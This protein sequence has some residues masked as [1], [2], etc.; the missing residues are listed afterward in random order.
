VDLAA[1]C[2]SAARQSA[3]RGGGSSISIAGALTRA[4]GRAKYDALTS[5]GRSSCS[6]ACANGAALFVFSGSPE[7][8]SWPCSPHPH[9]A[10]HAARPCALRSL[11][12][13]PCPGRVPH[14]QFPAALVPQPPQHDSSSDRTS[15]VA[16]T[17][18]HDEVLDGTASTLAG[19]PAMKHASNQ[20]TMATIVLWPTN[21]RIEMRVRLLLVLN[22]RATRYAGRPS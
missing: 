21:V 20:S 13:Q 16:P 17:A 18:Q 1:A 22:M 5:S 2:P 9:D 4:L 7:D 11:Q 6:D 14:A 3:V 8:G 19:A 15:S 10:L 12:Q